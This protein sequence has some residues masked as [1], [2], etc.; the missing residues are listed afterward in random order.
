MILGQNF[1]FLGS[2]YI[3]KFDLEM[4]FGDVLE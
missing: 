1:K 4:T 2:F 3:F